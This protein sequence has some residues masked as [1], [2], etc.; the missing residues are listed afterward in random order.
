MNMR[1][2]VLLF[3]GSVLLLLTGAGCQT[4]QPKVQTIFYPPLPDIP[5]LQFLTS[6]SSSTPWT[7]RRTSFTE[8]IV[9]QET[10][11]EGEIT[12]PYGVAARNGKIY[13]C[14]LGRRMVHVIDL[15]AK[16]RTRLGN[17]DQLGLPVNITIAA[18]G[19]KYV[20]DTDLGRVA[21][22]D[23]QDRFV[24]PIG[25]PQRCVPADLAIDGDTL[26]VCNLL[27]A[28]VEVWSR[29]GKLLRT[30]SKK[31][32][33][34]GEFQLPTNIEIS[35]GGEIFV[36]DTISSIVNV[37]DRQGRYLRSI[38]APG[39]RPGYHARPKGLAFDPRGDLFVA[40]AQWEVIQ[41]FAPAGNLLLFFG[42]ASPEPQGLGLPAGIA[43]DST[44]LEFFRPYV[45]K[46]FEP[47]A[48]LFVANQHGKNKI[49]VYAFGNTKKAAAAAATRPARTASARPSTQ[50]ATMPGADLQPAA[51]PSTQPAA[52]QPVT[53]PAGQ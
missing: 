29:D 31:G 18:D 51:P 47:E 39:D 30:I 5:R 23:A 6:F 52:P 3:L 14:D 4:S 25:D 2:L 53:R 41:V 12:S 49:V 46:D 10:T 37:Y 50:P 15:A 21:V 40:D 36:S 35:S 9:G 43:F 1:K 26:L 7:A 8:F 42:E 22:F 16:T 13:I 38:G 44:S 11:E 24:K 48:L 34:P 17:A 19:T 32:K 27:A 20:C 45:A 33:A 28:Q